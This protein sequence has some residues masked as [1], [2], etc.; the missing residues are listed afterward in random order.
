MWRRRLCASSFAVASYFVGLRDG[1]YAHSSEVHANVV[2]NSCVTLDEP[3]TRKL[4]ALELRG[5]PAAKSAQ[6]SV[7]CENAEI[8]LNVKWGERQSS[9]TLA[10]S[11]T[12]PRA[13]P[14]ILALAAVELLTE[15]MIV[16][17]L[18]PTEKPATPV[19]HS[20]LFTR[21]APPSSQPRASELQFDLGLLVRSLPSLDSN[22][23]GV[24]GGLLALV[25]PNTATG[26]F[27]V[28]A[29]ASLEHADV[30]LDFGK[31]VVNAGSVVAQGVWAHR[32]KFAPWLGMGLRGGVAWLHGE[33]EAP[34]VAKSFA[35]PWLGPEATVGAAIRIARDVAVAAHLDCGYAALAAVGH[36]AT[37][38]SSRFGYDGAWIALNLS[39]ALQ[40]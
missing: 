7:R 8:F 17:T 15:P 31:G 38:G 11:E 36:G 21:A 22:V 25:G 30:T 13:W 32:G 26:R 6:I 39:L 2:F 9:R 28:R 19:L 40:P 1:S 20:D 23:F 14:R 29:G 34:A 18:A 35:A 27:G 16:A 5:I 10:V 12:P 24:A 33:A 4:L 37:P 3:E